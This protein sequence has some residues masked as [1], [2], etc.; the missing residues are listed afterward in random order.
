MKYPAYRNV[1]WRGGTPGPER[2]ISKLFMERTKPTDERVRPGVVG[3]AG[4]IDRSFWPRGSIR[5]AANLAAMRLKKVPRR[6][7]GLIAEWLLPKAIERLQLMM[8]LAAQSSAVAG[9]A[10]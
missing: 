2:S 1:S 5:I 8:H 9:R 4:S 3:T 7:S 10:L 6:F